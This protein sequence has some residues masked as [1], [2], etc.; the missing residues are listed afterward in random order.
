[1]FRKYPLDLVGEAVYVEAAH[2]Y[3]LAVTRHAQQI[4]PELF[5]VT[6]QMEESP[7][8]VSATLERLLV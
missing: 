6:V 1:M 5:Q 2:L 7:K 3:Y 8:N 4:L